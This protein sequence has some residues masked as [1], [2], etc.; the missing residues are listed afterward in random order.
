MLNQQTDERRS[1]ER[2]SW[3]G[4]VQ[5]LP[6]ILLP[7]VLPSLQQARG[8]DLSESGLQ[9]RSERALPLKSTVLIE[10]QAPNH[11]EGIQVIGSVIWV[12]PA[13]TEQHWYLG[14]EFSDVGESACHGI[15][16]LL[17]R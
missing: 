9:V 12:S 13:A 17:K 3:Q 5:M 8:Q 16:A 15:Q 7:P 2:V 11:P 10:M 14:I 4:Q 6:L 1:S